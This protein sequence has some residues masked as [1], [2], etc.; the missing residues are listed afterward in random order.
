[1]IYSEVL[2]RAVPDTN[3]KTFLQV[4]T[5]QQLR[6]AASTIV[7]SGRLRRLERSTA[8]MRVGYDK[9]R[10]SIDIG[11]FEEF[12]VGNLSDDFTLIDGRVEFTSPQRAAAYRM[13]ALL[14]WVRRY[15]KDGS[16][17]E[18]GSGAGRNLLHLA[19]AGIRNPLIGLE[20]SP[21]SAELSRRAASEFACDIRFES[22]D[23][24]DALPSLGPVDVVFSVHAFEM[25]PRVFVRGL[26]NISR[27]QPRAA[28]F[29]EPI[30]EL[31]PKSLLGLIGR[32]RVR[33]LDRLKGFYRPA[34]ELGR[35]VEAKSLGYATNPLNPTAVMAVEFGGQASRTL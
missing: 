33:Q 20:L 1:M 11:S 2:R 34:S 25:M 13:D 3:P 14:E 32:L 24:T 21:V 27:L 15:A 17:V 28:I 12:V 10:S 23:V 8:D 26:A 31:W 30:E 29:F 7:R 19:R 16:I 18:F 9:V 4:A 35:V 5:M 22:C 6:L